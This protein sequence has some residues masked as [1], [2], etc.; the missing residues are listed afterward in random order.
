MKKTIIFDLDGTLVDIQPIFFRI[1]NVL[2][3]EF[4]YTPLTPEA[5]PSL[6]ELHLRKFIFDRLGWRFFLFPKI[7][8]RGREE[9]RRLVPEVDLFPGIAAL[10]PILRERGYRIGVVS[11]SEEKTV[12]ALLQK[13]KLET[14]FIYHSSLFGKAR[15]LKKAMQEQSLTTTNTLY[16]GDEIRDV[17]ACRKANLP[18][19]AVTWGL[20]SEASL[21]K[22]GAETV[23]TPN[24]LLAAIL[25]KR[26]A[27]PVTSS[28]HQKMSV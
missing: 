2:A 13:F 18:I 23:A 3:A 15:T 26:L 8:K 22:A 4:N 11:S 7:L 21:R 12:R 16:V 5:I 19:I 17:E 28:S 6:R 27:E 25:S 14:D 20:N 10:F 24:E 1:I 9:Y